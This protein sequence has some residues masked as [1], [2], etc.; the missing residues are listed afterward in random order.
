L[1]ADAMAKRNGRKQN[2]KQ[3]PEKERYYECWFSLRDCEPPDMSLLGLAAVLEVMAGELREME[4]KGVHMQYM[5]EDQYLLKTTDPE[6]AKDFYFEV[7]EDEEDDPGAP[8]YCQLCRSKEMEW[9]GITLART[10]DQH[11]RACRAAGC[12]HPPYYT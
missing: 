9:Y 7:R 6:V 11:I 4:A 3:K 12:E 5:G 1:E 8:G 2:Q 10:P